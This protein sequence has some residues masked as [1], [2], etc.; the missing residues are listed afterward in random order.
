MPPRIMLTRILAC[1]AVGAFVILAMTARAW[2][3][4][5]ATYYPPLPALQ[6]A[7]PAPSRSAGREPPFFAG[8]LAAHNRARRAVGVQ[9]LQW[10]DRLSQIAQGWAEHLGGDRCAMRHSGVSGLGENLAWAAG[11]HLSPVDVVR[12]WVDEARAFDP[13]DS[14]CDS[15]A[16]CGHY[17][18]V[19]WRGTKFVGCGMVSCGDSEVWVCNY[20]PPGNY[21]GERPY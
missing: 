13:A 21:V 4:R 7:M 16:V 2:A 5:P 19:V 17:T 3:E 1:C 18:Q 14:V 15:G 12:M 6:G 11:Q 8:M 10:S 9:D 20:S